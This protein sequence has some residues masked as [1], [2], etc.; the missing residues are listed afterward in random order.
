[1]S[2]E[3]AIDKAFA[4][5]D[6]IEET[7]GN[8]GNC[9]L[10]VRTE[11]VDLGDG[12]VSPLPLLADR[13]P[14]RADPP[15]PSALFPF[16]VPSTRPN[17]SLRQQQLSLVPLSSRATINVTLRQDEAPDSEVAFGARLTTPKA[18]RCGTAAD[19]VASE[20]TTTPSL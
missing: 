1:M 18:E 6:L 19:S 15:S 7:L 14:P 3:L 8:K 16:L 2:Q 10:G 9:L 17:S 12:A 11:M 20:G 5:S 4:K 13:P